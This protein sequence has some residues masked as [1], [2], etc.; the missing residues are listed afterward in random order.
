[1]PGIV[2]ADLLALAGEQRAGVIITTALRTFLEC[3]GRAIAR[4]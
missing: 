1:M 3:D 2:A 4:D